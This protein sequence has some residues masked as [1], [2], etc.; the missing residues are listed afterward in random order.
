MPAGS[1]CA[2]SLIP[3]TTMR[4]RC[5]TGLAR[6]K[7]PN[8][9]PWDETWP[10]TAL[11]EVLKCDVSLGMLEG[12]YR[13]AG[14]D[15]SIR[16]MQRRHGSTTSKIVRICSYGPRI[17]AGGRQPSSTKS[18]QS[19]FCPIRSQNQPPVPL[20]RAQPRRMKSEQLEALV[21][22]TENTAITSTAETD[23]VEQ[24]EYSHRRR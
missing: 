2:G 17:G 14:Q 13:K 3:L 8:L 15:Q 7:R 1:F 4:L 21:D 20:C 12:Y 23:R 11:F 19:L 22:A 16:R 5:R 10:S 24:V 6:K 9:I 18:P